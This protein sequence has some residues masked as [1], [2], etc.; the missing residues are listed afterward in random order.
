MSKIPV[1]ANSKG[2]Q[3]LENKETTLIQ[4]IL[5]QVNGKSHSLGGEDIDLNS[6][7]NGQ[8]IQIFSSKIKFPKEIVA[9][10]LDKEKS[11]VDKMSPA[12]MSKM[13]ETK[14]YDD[15]L[16]DDKADY[17][18]KNTAEV[19]KAK[20]LAK[21]QTIFES[22]EEF[23]KAKGVQDGKL[24]SE[25]GL[26]SDLNPIGSEPIEVGYYNKQVYQ[27]GSRYRIPIKGEP[28]ITPNLESPE[29]AN[30]INSLTG[31]T[32]LKTNPISYQEQMFTNEPMVQQNLFKKKLYN[33]KR[34]GSYQ[35]AEIAW[36]DNTGYR[37][38][39]LDIAV[40]RDTVKH[41]FDD[42]GLPNW[43]HIEVYDQQGNPV[44]KNGQRLVNTLPEGDFTFG[45]RKNALG[46]TVPTIIDNDNS[47]YQQPKFRTRSYDFTSNINQ[48]EFPG[49]PYKSN[50]LINPPVIPKTPITTP[51]IT[52][53]LANPN[54]PLESI[55]LEV[56]DELNKAKFGE[57]MNLFT[58][59][60]AVPYLRN[61]NQTVAYNR[62]IPIN[63]LAQE[64]GQNFLN[65]T[66]D[67]SD[68]SSQMVQGINAD[69]YAKTLQ[70]IDKVNLNNYQADLQNDNQNNQ[71]YMNTFNNNERMKNENMADYVGRVQTVN[72]SFSAEQEEALNRIQNYRLQRAESNDDFSKRRLNNL[73]TNEKF[74]PTKF[75]NGTYGISTNPYFDRIN[76]KF[77]SQYNNGSQTAN[78]DAQW[79]KVMKAQGVSDEIINN[80]IKHKKGL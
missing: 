13:F 80:I 15:V 2:G 47:H 79:V 30:Y 74:V 43:K 16:K 48:P 42:T 62:F 31:L 7:S 40:R 71:L 37:K 6:M 28:L 54:N 21:L 38:S 66:Y 29:Y 35:R 41:L 67:N 64:R 39:P 77:E 78:D 9:G 59:E 68:A 24:L 27:T 56:P 58:R 4:G 3:N 22:Q 5:S 20:N 34:V 72:D 61:D 44:I 73:L 70:G 57:Y 53:T 76:S 49:L 11:K 17:R 26:N 18:A 23:K 63:T 10:I 12:D 75:K 8:P 69:N 14:I 25:Q 36:D 52:N 45:E 65:R 46:E 60:K 50:T 19:M 33:D 1:L 51:S 55:K 32:T